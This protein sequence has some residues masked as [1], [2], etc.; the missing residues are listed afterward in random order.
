MD[1]L[2]SVEVRWFL[3]DESATAE[4]LK[5]FEK[6]EP[7]RLRRDRYL[8]TGRGEIGFKAR[9]PEREPAKVE[10]KYLLGSL[11]PVELA[12]RVVGIVERWQKLSLVLEDSELEK[13]GQWVAVDKVRLLRKFAW[14]KD[15]LNEVSPTDHPDAGAG[16]ELTKLGGEPRLK[17]YTLGVEAFGPSTQLL[18]ILQSVCRTVFSER[19]DLHFDQEASMSYPAWLLRLPPSPAWTHRISIDTPYYDHPAQAR[20]PNGTIPAGT[21]CLITSNAGSC[22]LVSTDKNIA[23]YVSTDALIPR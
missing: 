20:P 14:A 21:L 18:T 16:F 1:I 17:G 9:I 13:Q 11:G 4:L 15:G 2:E 23:G 3:Q 12:P 8:L 6:I 19:P 7:E 10:T 22:V 5:W